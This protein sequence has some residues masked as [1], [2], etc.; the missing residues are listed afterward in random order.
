[1]KTKWRI[2]GLITLALFISLLALPR[3]SL[4]AAGQNPAMVSIGEVNGSAG[5]VVDVPVKIGEITN[6][7]AAYGV[8]IHF[9][10]DY[11][12]VVGINPSHGNTTETGCTKDNEGCF[13]SNFSNEDGFLRAA[14]ADPDAGDHPITK[15][16]DLFTIQ[17][18][19]L[20]TDFIGEKKFTIPS[21]DVEAL[22]FVDV[23]G[24]TLS[25]EVNPGKIQVVKAEDK[26]QDQG[27]EPDK[28][29]VPPTPT[30]KA[31]DSVKVDKKD[32][33]PGLLPKTWD[34][35]Y[36]DTYLNIAIGA[37]A[38][39]LVTLWMYKKRKEAVKN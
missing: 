24:K 15:D 39:L 30:D 33:K 20:K 11:L 14:W 29:Q 5:D 17:V 35:S 16:T 23:S 3:P 27:N 13:W 31:D 25:V 28:D 12:K 37:L 1:M 10:K 36:I 9:D 22:S 2:M 6:G 4:A 38:V 26:G 32:S 18:E 19:V 21:N 8:E 7:I 34:D